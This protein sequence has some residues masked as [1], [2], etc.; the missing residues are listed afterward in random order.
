MADKY[1]PPKKKVHNIPPAGNGAIY[2][3]RVADRLGYHCVGWFDG[4]TIYVD[5]VHTPPQTVIR[6]FID[7]QA[8]LYGLISRVRDLGLNLV[9]VNLI[10]VISD[11]S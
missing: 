3:I 4:T 9:S 1:I 6:A 7:D 5:D 10:E 2:E 8:A 11:A